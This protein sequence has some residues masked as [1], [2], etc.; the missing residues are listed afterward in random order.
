MTAA[1]ASAQVKDE[2]RQA[3]EQTMLLGALDDVSLGVLAERSTLRCYARGEPVLLAGDPG[4]DLLVVASG[5]LKVLVRSLDGANMVLANVGPGDTLGELTLLDRAPRSATVEAA[6]PSQVVWIPGETVLGIIRAH[7]EI[8]EE[9]LL[10]QAAMIRRVSSLVSDLVFLDLPRRVAKYVLERCDRNGLADLG[11]SQSELAE[12]V[13]GVRQSVN[14]AL[15]GL[16]RRGWITVNGRAVM[17]LDRAA[18]EQY[19]AVNVP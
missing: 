7:P 6:E 10:Q 11:G 9:L 15:R 3:I 1:T 17:V 14:V 5:R 19:A 16:E 18:L 4:G 13:G 12:A 8:T 2:C